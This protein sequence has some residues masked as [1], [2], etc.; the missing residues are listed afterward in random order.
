VNANQ[1]LSRCA[2]SIVVALAW[3][4]PQQ[5]QAQ[6]FAGLGAEGAAFAQVLPG[7]QLT[8]PL[9][10]AAHPDFRTEWWYVTATLT[11]DDGQDYGVQW[12]LFRSALGAT[13]APEW[14]TPQVWMGHAAVTSATMHISTER[15]A[16]GG[17]GQAGATAAPFEAWIDDWQLRAPTN[18]QTL[19]SL[20]VLS[21]HASG[22]Q[23]HYDLALTADG[24]LVE[25]G[26][27]GYSVKSTSENASYYY[28]QPFY[29]VE[30]QLS[31]PKGD[32]Q[33]TGQAWLDREWSSQPLGRTQ[34]GWDWVALTMENGARLMGFQLRDTSGTAFTSGSWI[35]P[36]GVSSPLRPGALTMTPLE[37]S[38]VAGREI[39]LAWHITL[40]EQDLDITTE[41][42]NDQSWM[43]L[44]IPYWEGPI[45]FSGTHTGRGYLEMTGY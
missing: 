14:G 10:H 26:D 38:P 7:Y 29:T 11:G 9:D 22:P 27:N 19:G 36:T 4:A 31:L 5:A 30:G 17:I 33:V 32:I 40:A 8:F 13:D 15:F 44:S 16:R 41:A 1:I 25:H 45:R 20:D 37:I 24:P 34:Q 18:T 12:T 3:N 39:P 6:G 23:F 2:Q 43:A 21:M 28:S 42:L 35:S